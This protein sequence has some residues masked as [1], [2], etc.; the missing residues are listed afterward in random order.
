MYSGS[1]YSLLSSTSSCLFSAIMVKTTNLFIL[2]PLSL[3]LQLEK[4]ILLY[5]EILDSHP[6]ISSQ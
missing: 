5:I 2:K 4:K 6:K 3:S 1:Q